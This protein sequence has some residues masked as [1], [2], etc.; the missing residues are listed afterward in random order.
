MRESMVR[1]TPRFSANRTLRE[2]TEQYYLP[3][4]A[5]Y[6]SRAAENGA[7]GA[8]IV[9]W[10]RTL[11]Q[12]WSSA[13]F[14]DMEVETSDLHHKFRLQ[15]YLGELPTEAVRVELYADPYDGEAPLRHV[16]T[17]T[18]SLIGAINGYEYTACVLA[19]RPAEHFT[20][21]LI[22]FHPDA[23][24]PLEAPQILWGR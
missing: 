10:R 22:P 24:I 19:E 21:R 7:R 23:V 3:A 13:H 12:W 17:R 8:Q 16:M 14:G 4:A 9:N 18:C 5:A 20:P 2:Y 1:L 11:E 6:Q 15:V